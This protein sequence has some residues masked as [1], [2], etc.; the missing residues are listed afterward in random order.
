MQELEEDDEES[1]FVASPLPPSSPHALEGPGNSPSPFS[2]PTRTTPANA[3]SYQF[4]HFDPPRT[5]SSADGSFPSVPGS[6]TSDVQS[7][8]SS[9]SSDSG[10]SPSSAKDSSRNADNV[11]FFY[12]E[13]GDHHVCKLCW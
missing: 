4:V 10:S 11:W 7:L 5:S 2:M 9:N 13:E 3:V 1:P 12:I 6:P 8:M